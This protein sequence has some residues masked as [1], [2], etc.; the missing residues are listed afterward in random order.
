MKVPLQM[1]MMY[2]GPD[3]Q[4]ISTRRAAK[5][6]G[7]SDQTIRDRIDDGTIAARRPWA[8]A[9]W[10]VSKLCVLAIM[11]RMVSGRENNDQT[12]TTGR[13]NPGM[14]IGK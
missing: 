9:Q 11:E 1:E 10:R 8:N 7:C 6:L 3:D 14:K 2:F 12:D 4:L 13:Q 5:L